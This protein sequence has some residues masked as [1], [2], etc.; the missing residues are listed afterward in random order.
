MCTRLLFWH[1]LHFSSK[2]S[3]K[4]FA[5]NLPDS[6]SNPLTEKTSR[7][8]IRNVCKFPVVMLQV[9]AYFPYVL[10]SENELKPVIPLIALSIGQFFVHVFCVCAFLSFQDTFVEAFGKFTDTE[11]ITATSYCL[12]ALLGQS[13]IRVAFYCNHSHVV[14]YQSLLNKL[15]SQLIL[16]EDAS[17]KIQTQEFLQW[18]QKIQQKIKRL[19]FLV[20]GMFF[21]NFS[22][23]FASLFFQ[24]SAPFLEK[25]TVCQMVMFAFI[26]LNF[27]AS[28]FLINGLTIW[29]SSYILLKHVAL[30]IINR[31]VSSSNSLTFAVSE[32][33]LSNVEEVEKLFEQFNGFSSTYFITWFTY[34]MI[35]L[36][37]QFYQNLLWIRYQ[38]YL[39]TLVSTPTI[40][41]VAGTMYFLCTTCSNATTQVAHQIGFS[42]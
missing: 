22:I 31:I 42:T 4:I 14:H 26:T 3:T 20:S 29:L 28:M 18:I 38:F 5:G 34:A 32:I 13:A 24:A 10:T 25:I 33:L 16:L 27:S 23:F 7:I 2:M 15:F 36:V 40:V 9:G 8:A 12:V 35:T 1:N 30:R 17:I 6:N 11:K 41:S 37:H 19:C 39:T 21:V